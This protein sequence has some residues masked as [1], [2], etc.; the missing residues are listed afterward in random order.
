M[1]VKIPYVMYVIKN[2]KRKNA[3]VAENR[4]TMKKIQL[5]K[6]QEEQQ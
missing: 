3:L 4:I 2:F 1:I 5:Q 6:N